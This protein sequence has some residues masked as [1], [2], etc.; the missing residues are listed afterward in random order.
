MTD[1]QFISFLFVQDSSESRVKVTLTVHQDNVGFS[2]RRIVEFLCLIGYRPGFISL[3]P[4]FDVSLID[5]YTLNQPRFGF[6]H[7][8]SNRVQSLY[9]ALN[10]FMSNFYKKLKK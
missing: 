3:T 7:T 6:Q 5:Q 4:I 9:P 2:V 10:S 1:F 8:N